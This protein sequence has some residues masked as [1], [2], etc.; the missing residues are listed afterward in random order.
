[1]EQTFLYI[2]AYR[3]FFYNPTNLK[4]PKKTPCARRTE[5]QFEVVFEAINLKQLRVELFY[6]PAIDKPTFAC[7]GCLQ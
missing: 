1:M 7:T 5:L 6:D 3:T 4:A 2:L